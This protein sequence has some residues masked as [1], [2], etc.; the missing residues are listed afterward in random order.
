MTSAL[1]VPTKARNP[2]LD[3][4]QAGN[5]NRSAVAHDYARGADRPIAANLNETSVTLAICKPPDVITAGQSRRNII[6]GYRLSIRAFRVAAGFIRVSRALL[7]LHL[8]RLDKA[9]RRAQRDL[10][11]R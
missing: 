11:A 3:W 4:E 1:K 2:G 8:L 7:H 5:L 6:R 10:I 9:F